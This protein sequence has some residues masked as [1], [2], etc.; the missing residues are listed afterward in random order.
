MERKQIYQIRGEIA[1][2]RKVK[3]NAPVWHYSSGSWDKYPLKA[4]YFYIKNNFRIAFKHFGIPKILS[5]IK[6]IYVI[7]CNPFIMYQRDFAA[8]KITFDSIFVRRAR[9][10]NIF[11]NF[12]LITFAL[13]QNFFSILG[14]IKSKNRDLSRIKR[15]KYSDYY[16]NEL[17]VPYQI[18]ENIIRYK[19]PGYTNFLEP[20]NYVL[21]PFYVENTEVWYNKFRIN[22]PINWKG[23]FTNCEISDGEMS[24][25]KKKVSFDKRW[26][27]MTAYITYFKDL[28]FESRG[29]FEALTAGRYH[30]EV[31][32]KK[33]GSKIS[34]LKIVK[35]FLNKEF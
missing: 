34:I 30:S 8:N 32:K 31:C 24:F 23:I 1:G 12:F 20:K 7:G 19:I 16:K 15:I 27:H 10:S 13:F 18:F 35:K 14:I 4:S 28:L 29:R 5:R 33:K 3:T 11:F 2:F 17:P 22:Y 9:Y 21:S 26:S 25:C 6:D